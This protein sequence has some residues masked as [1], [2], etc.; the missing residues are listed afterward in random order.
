[1][2]SRF[3]ESCPLFV[4]SRPFLKANPMPDPDPQ[5]ITSAKAAQALHV[6]TN[7]QVVISDLCAKSLELVQACDRKGL[8]DRERMLIAKATRDLLLLTRDHLAEVGLALCE[9]QTANLELLKSRL[10]ANGEVS[11]DS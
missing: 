2:V 1:M 9:Y 3:S 11:L 10:D 7:I 5:A 8:T 4:P 6:T